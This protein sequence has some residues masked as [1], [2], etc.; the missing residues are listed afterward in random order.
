MAAGDKAVPALRQGLTAADPEVRREAAAMLDRLFERTVKAQRKNYS[1]YKIPSNRMTKQVKKWPPQ[2]R[3]QFLAH[4]GFIK[5]CESHYTGDLRN[6]RRPTVGD[7]TR[8]LRTLTRYIKHIHT[9]T[10]SLESLFVC[11][12]I[13][14]KLDQLEP[15]LGKAHWTTRWAVR[16]ELVPAVREAVRGR[17]PTLA[18]AE[19]DMF[20]RL[21]EHIRPLCDEPT[22]KV[23]ELIV[24]R[25]SRKE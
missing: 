23:R 12:A 10:G 5:S 19:A 22:A 13:V 3:A 2:M 20:V 18:H 17:G 11:R 14:K 21:C 15:G 24:V 9:A 25:L 16:R 4:P 7:Y 8:L 6:W 1:A